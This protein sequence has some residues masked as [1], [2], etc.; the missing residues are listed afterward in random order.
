MTDRI[1]TLP[2]GSLIQHGPCNDRIY[3]MKA[4]TAAAGLPLE[5]I[6]R[7][8]EHG[9]TKIFAKVPGRAAK[10]FLAA[11]YRA[12]AKI[13]GLYNRKDDG[14]FLG[15]FL[16]GRRAEEP[17]REKLDE[18][19]SRVRS[20]SPVSR[21]EGED[22]FAVG[23]CEE[24]DAEEMAEVYRTVFPSYPFPIRDPSYLK[25]TMREN[26]VYFAAR[27]GDRIAALSSAETDDSTS[28]VEMTDF[29]TLPEWR[30]HRLAAHL[31]AAMEPAMRTRGIRT[32]YTIARAL[33][34]GMNVTFARSGY[35]FA[36]RLRN[37]T[38][39]S[40]GIESMNVWYKPLE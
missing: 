14:L 40:G 1:E 3:L 22:G 24:T 21:A 9:Y 20:E 26:I 6:D 29:A 30:G 37:N 36:G 17:E 35:E 12:E 11:G 5:L 7:A 8:R 18:I 27:K 19:L 31:L 16:D 23:M 13:P 34:P 25:Q 38:N 2:D 32:A 28:S 39:I 10:G 4:G 15:C 33:S